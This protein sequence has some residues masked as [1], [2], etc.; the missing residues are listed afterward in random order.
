MSIMDVKLELADNQAMSAS[1]TQLAMTNVLD[2]G[3]LTVKNL[4]IGPGTPL[5]LNIRIVRAVTGGPTT[6]DSSCTFRLQEGA[7]NV[8]TGSFIGQEFRTTRWGLYTAG[9]W[10]ARAPLDYNVASKRYLRLLFRKSAKTA[11]KAFAAGSVDA[12]ISAAVPETNVGT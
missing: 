10:V 3:D 7:S 4:A 11:A 1:N 5:Y 9:K 6:W 8:A 12:W 2:L